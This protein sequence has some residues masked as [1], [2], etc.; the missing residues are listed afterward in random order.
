VLII[1]I[2]EMWHY[3]QRKTNRVWI[4]KAYDWAKDRLIDW[5]C[6]KRDEASFRRLF[7]RLEQWRPRLYCTDDYV[8]Y[9]TVLPVG[10]HYVGKD[11]SVRLDATTV[12]SGIGWHPA[13][14]APSW[15]PDP[16]R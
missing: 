7:T 6:G 15:P 13:A 12:V 16:A 11:E 3:L 5:E 1:Q 2:D 8:V 9:D 4:W 14:A 10:R